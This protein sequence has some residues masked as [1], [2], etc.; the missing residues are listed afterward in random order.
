MQRLQMNNTHLKKKKRQNGPLPSMGLF[1]HFDPEPTLPCSYA[2][3]CVAREMMAEQ[4]PSTRLTACNVSAARCCHVGG[5]GGAGM[6]GDD[7][8]YK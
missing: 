4:V 7:I 2:P 5:F 1:I 8:F 6:P 3:A